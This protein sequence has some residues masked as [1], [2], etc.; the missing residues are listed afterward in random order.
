MCKV[1]PRDR[2]LVTCQDSLH[3]SCGGG[4]RH[5]LMHPKPAWEA[6]S[7]PLRFVFD[8][9]FGHTLTCWGLFQVFAGSHSQWCSGD[10]VMLMI[11]LI[12]LGLSHAKHML[13]PWSTLSRPKHLCFFSELCLVVWDEMRQRTGIPLSVWDE[14]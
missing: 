9:F 10:R 11:K 2:H 13:S 5:Q 12:K 8:S 6:L 14:I 7:G 4:R 1:Q 3:Y